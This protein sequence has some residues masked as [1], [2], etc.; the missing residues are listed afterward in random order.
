MRRCQDQVCCS[1]FPLSWCSLQVIWG[2]VVI[3]CRPA[4]PCFVG[5]ELSLCVCVCVRFISPQL[6]VFTTQS[7]DPGSGVYLRG[8][9][10]YEH[11]ESLV[12]CR[13]CAPMSGKLDCLG[14][15][16]LTE[17]HFKLKDMTVAM[18]FLFPL[19]FFSSPSYPI[20][21]LTSS[22]VP[23]LV[24]ALTSL[25][26]LSRFRFGKLISDSKFVYVDICILVILVK[27]SQKVISLFS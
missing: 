6:S 27:V 20:L 12:Y 13:C 14:P 16:G 3:R 2:Q 1:V 5:T 10:C 22:S 8:I 25:P 26:S 21:F 19:L 24:F 17:I 7:R 9:M 15:Y 18:W 4:P 11:V 23:L